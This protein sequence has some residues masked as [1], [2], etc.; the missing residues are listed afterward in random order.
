MTLMDFSPGRGLSPN[1]ST[2]ETEVAGLI[3]PHDPT[4]K[5][6]RRN[7]VAWA[8]HHA[9][10]AVPAVAP[11][12][13][14]GPRYP[15]SGPLSPI[16]VERLDYRRRELAF[17]VPAS[18]IED[19]LR[20]YDLSDEAEDQRRAE[21]QR[22]KALSDED[23]ARTAL[24]AAAQAEPR[25]QDSDFHAFSVRI[26]FEIENSGDDYEDATNP[27]PKDEISEALA[28]WIKHYQALGLIEGDDNDAPSFHLVCR[29]ED[30]PLAPSSLLT[31]P[32]ARFQVDALPGATLVIS[33]SVSPINATMLYETAR[34]CHG[35]L[36]QSGGE[37][38]PEVEQAESR[39]DWLSRLAMPTER[40]ARTVERWEVSGRNPQTYALYGNETE[41]PL[42]DAEI[43]WLV[44]GRIPR[45]ALTLLAGNG[46]AGK[47]SF[48]HEWISALGGKEV[49]RPR[50]ILGEKVSGRFVAALIAREDD[51]GDI[52]FRAARHA[53][54]WGS[55]DY[56]VMNDVSKSLEHYLDLLLAMPVVDL[57]VLDPVRAFFTG[58]EKSPGDVRTFCEPLLKF[59]RA[60]RCAIVLVHHITKG[61]VKDAGEVK[62]LAELRIRIGGS[63]ALVDA[64]RMTIGMIRRRSGAVEV[65]PV[66]YNY[67]AEKV[68]LPVCHGLLYWQNPETFTLDL[69]HSDGVKAGP[70]SPNQPADVRV[71]AAIDRR[72]RSANI[73]RKSGKSG[74]FESKPP[75]LAGLSRAS[76]LDAI[77]TLEA[78]GEITDGQAGLHVAPANE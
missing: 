68:W 74:L 65:G 7:N 50:S 77:G 20:N 38:T 44:E 1:A 41:R 78:R 30:E 32:D 69:I 33:S 15:S 31:F 23:D 40:L 10:S 26:T 9:E 5:E 71:K 14:S 2:D 46:G 73:V 24:A 21:Y 45:A 35:S 11:A 29:A 25:Q 54:I 75:E 66:K 42:G 61:S 37:S 56:L 63:A 43:S 58:D 16:E 19:C 76:I 18:E 22:Q 72:N 49:A 64:T 67:P 3:G 28:P 8:A 55:S 51:T 39:V 52:N 17:M 70:G 12:R 47:S 59:A 27:C 36:T 48:V 60:K 6:G 13:R 4:T 53:K 57:V 62:S 34:G